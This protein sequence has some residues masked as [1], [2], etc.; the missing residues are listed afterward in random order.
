MPG[1]ALEAGD[2][3]QVKN[4]LEALTGHRPPVRT[5]SRAEVGARHGF[6]GSRTWSGRKGGTNETQR[7]PNS[8]GVIAALGGLLFGFDTAVISGTTAW[9]KSGFVA[10]DRGESVSLLPSISKESVL[11]FM[12]GFTVAGALIGTI[13]GSIGLANRPTPLVDAAFCSR[14][15]LCISSP[16]S[17]VDWRGAGGRS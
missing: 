2:L 12:L 4:Q 5:R 10:R 13:L 16:P 17:D 14:W 3:K 15:P 1:P 9:L 11:E 7:N 6:P 8:S